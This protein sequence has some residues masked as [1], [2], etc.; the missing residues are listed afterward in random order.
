MKEREN[1]KV[2]TITLVLKIIK[3]DKYSVAKTERKKKAKKKTI[4]TG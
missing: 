1:G 3:G 4:N 2:V